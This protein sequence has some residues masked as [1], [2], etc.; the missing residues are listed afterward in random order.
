MYGKDL[1]DFG[2]LED[3]KPSLFDILEIYEQAAEIKMIIITY[4]RAKCIGCNYCCE[5]APERWRMSKKDGKSVLIGSK[6][7]K[8]M[9]TA[10]VGTHEWEANQKA[11]EACPVKDYFGEGGLNPYLLPLTLTITCTS[12]FST[13]S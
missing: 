9:Y 13:A 8:G 12:S 5:L 10:K 7:K 2:N 4:Q 1:P 3:L 11:A 6:P